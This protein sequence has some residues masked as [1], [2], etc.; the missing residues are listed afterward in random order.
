MNMGTLTFRAIQMRVQ[1]QCFFSFYMF[2]SVIFRKGFYP[3]Y[4]LKL[5]L[6]P[7]EF[8]SD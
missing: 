5:K 1:I 3:D 7:R 8:I 6:N 4:R 2:A